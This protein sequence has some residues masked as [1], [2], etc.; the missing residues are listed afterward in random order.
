MM[1][2]VPT[3]A[4]TVSNASCLSKCIFMKY[5]SAMKIALMSIGI[6]GSG[7]TTILKPLAER[8]GLA[9]INRDDIREEILGDA[10]DQ[11]HNEAVWQEAN[12]RTIEALA[13][14][15]GVVLDGTFVE[16]WKRKDMVSLLHE[17]GASAIIGVVADVPLPVALERNRART[18]EVPESVIEKLYKIRMAEPPTLEEGFDA[19]IPLENLSAL[20]TALT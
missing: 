13:A 15:K 1:R 4:L 2:I 11:S 18:R 8:Y 17:A 5:T 6:P 16:S 14:D 7:K 9:Y 19:I 12:R 10:R 20:E 3:S